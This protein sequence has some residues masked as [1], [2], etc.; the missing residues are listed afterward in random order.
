M[1]P[2]IIDIPTVPQDKQDPDDPN[3]IIKVTDID[4]YLWKEKHK[5]AS[6]KLDKYETDM[7]RAVILIFHQCTPNLKNGI[8][9]ADTFPAIWV[10]QDPIMLLKL[11]QSLCCSYDAKTQSIMALVASH[12]RLFTYYQ[13]DGDDNHNT[14]RS[15][16]LMSKPLRHMTVLV[17]LALHLPS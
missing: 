4:I 2:V 11:I 14:T 17:Q 9:A 6:A 10:T 13:Q 7:A 1:T 16:A 12:K 5:K 8:E 3:N 15:S